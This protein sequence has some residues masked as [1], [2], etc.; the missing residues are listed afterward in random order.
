MMYVGAHVSRGKRTALWSQSLL[1]PSCVFQ[2][3]NS[4][5]QTG[6]ASAFT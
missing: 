1:P 2:Q 4:G 6:V 3:S 5:H